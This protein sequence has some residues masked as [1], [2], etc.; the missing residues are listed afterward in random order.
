MTE[1]ADV[2]ITNCTA[3]MHIAAAVKTSVVALFALTNP[4]AQGGP[5]RVPHR[6]LFHDVPCRLCSSRVRPD[7][8]ECLRQVTPWQ[9]VDAAVDLLNERWSVPAGGT[10]SDLAAVGTQR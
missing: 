4:P 9:E 8:E 3:P 7:D 5:W 6:Q 2:T 10:P 1:R